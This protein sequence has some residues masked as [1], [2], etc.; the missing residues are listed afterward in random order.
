MTE[1]LVT[2]PSG[3]V[4]LHYNKKITVVLYRESVI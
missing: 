3:I 1:I 2:K 4:I